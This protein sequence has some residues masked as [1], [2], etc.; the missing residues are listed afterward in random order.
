MITKYIALKNFFTPNRGFKEGNTYF[1]DEE[2]GK[3]ME[4][5]K[6]LKKENDYLG[7]IKEEKK[8]KTEPVEEKKKDKKLKDKL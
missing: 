1:L 3:I 7:E 2:E 4:E 5:R 8:A 6:L